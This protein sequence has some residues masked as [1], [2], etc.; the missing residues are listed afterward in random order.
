MNMLRAYPLA[1]MLTSGAASRLVFAFFYIFTYLLSSRSR[2]GPRRLG[3]RTPPCF[4]APYLDC[5]PEYR[6]THPC[7]ALGQRRSMEHLS[8]WFRLGRAMGLPHI[9]ALRYKK[10]AFIAL[11][12]SVGMVYFAMVYGPTAA[13]F[14]RTVR[15]APALQRGLCQLQLRRYPRGGSGADHR[16]IASLGHGDFALDLFVPSDHGPTLITFVCISYAFSC[17]R[18]LI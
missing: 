1:L 18:S 5:L 2:T 3:C 7:R 11:A 8:S 4:T 17:S 15:H 9:L 10:P 12:L 14:L 13:L 6:R 16:Y